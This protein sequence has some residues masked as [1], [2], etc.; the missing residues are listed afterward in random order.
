LEKKYFT[1]N[2]EKKLIYLLLIFLA[3]DHKRGFTR[4]SLG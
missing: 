3:R 4:A 1:R 2:F